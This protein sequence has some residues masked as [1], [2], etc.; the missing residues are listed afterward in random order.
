ML[1]AEEENA[2]NDDDVID[3]DNDDDDDDEMLARWISR[4][5]CST[6]TDKFHLTMPG[7][8]ITVH[9]AISEVARL[10]ASL[11]AIDSHET[12]PNVRPASL[13]SVFEQRSNLVLFKWALK[14]L[15]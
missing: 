4:R 14:K 9:R 3:D 5:S 8:I 11:L 13:M 10:D 2:D 7:I 6:S 12:L 15:I 1:H